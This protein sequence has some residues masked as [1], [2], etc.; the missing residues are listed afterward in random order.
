[1][2]VKE[3]PNFMIIFLIYLS[4][5]PSSFGKDVPYSD[6]KCVSFVGD[7]TKGNLNWWDYTYSGFTWITCSVE[8]TKV[9][10]TDIKING[11]NCF[12]VDDWF[13]RREF[14]A[15]EEI[16]ITHSCMD[17]VTIELTANGKTSLIKLE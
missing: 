16:K 15:G 1:M 13:L 2:N 17:A 9:R 4:L 10:I 7:G 5:S 14:V 8:A 12:P 3:M 11:G 6:F